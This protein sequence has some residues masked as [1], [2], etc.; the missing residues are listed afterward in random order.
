MA[1][2]FMGSTIPEVFLGLTVFRWFM[3]YRVGEQAVV[4][5]TLPSGPGRPTVLD[6]PPATSE[7][8]LR[9]YRTIGQA[10]VVAGVAGS[11]LDAWL[12]AG[13]LD[14]FVNWA[15]RACIWAGSTTPHAVTGSADGS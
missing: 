3:L 4:G 10:T 5:L 8:L 1:F 13:Y 12:A 9:S 15:T 7:L 14:T 6:V 2:G 11:L